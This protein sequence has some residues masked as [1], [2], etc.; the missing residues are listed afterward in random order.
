MQEQE[1]EIFQS[2]E[3][4]DKN[5]APR[6]YKIFGAA[7][8]LNLFAI[9][10]IGQTNLLT[11]KGCDSPFVNR[12]CQVL[13]TVYVGSVLFGSD[14]GYVDK[15]YQKT[16][17][18]DADITF[19][20]M[21]NEKPFEYP[22]GYFAPS[23]DELAMMQNPTNDFSMTTSGIPGIPTNPTITGGTNLMNTPQVTPKPNKNAV[24]G[25]PPDSPFSFGGANPIGANPPV[26]RVKSPRM[27]L[28]RPPKMKNGSQNLEEKVIAENK[29]SKK[30]DIQTT[31]DQT[32]ATENKD[33]A[34]SD[35]N[36]VFINKKP[37]KKFAEDAKKD[38]DNKQV[39]LS[40]PFK[41]VITASL[42]LGKDG[43]TVVLK[44][45]KPLEAKYDP[46]MVKLAQ[47]AILAVGDSGW[48]GYLKNLGVKNITFTLEQDDKEIKATVLSD[49]K[50]INAA[51]SVASSLN[52]LISIGKLTADGDDKV[53]LEKANSTVEEPKSFKLNF[54][55][56]KQEALD[57]IK[58]KLDKEAVKPQSNSTAQSD[59]TSLKTAK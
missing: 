39:D 30:D 49:Q 24:I 29:N 21:S 26:K 5:Y 23:P 20:E 33:E 31:A 48:F 14:Y 38:I 2:Y 12:V 1:K 58:R 13:D 52:T 19:I 18:E 42:E 6:F 50:D 22:A 45:P 41:V 3:I 57:M 17:L 37:M 35:K 53:F 46:K 25:N 16:E 10:I 7:A 56:P 9:F 15:D 47:D 43:K 51:K 40:A 55:I 32:D 34:A 28:P 44:N 54:T 27:N 36:G 11:Q 59:N 8:V 4:K